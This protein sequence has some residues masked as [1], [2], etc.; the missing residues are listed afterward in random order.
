MAFGLGVLRLAPAAF[1]AAT[2]R[3]LVAAGRALNGSG[4]GEAP[5][6]GALDALM[7]RF[8]DIR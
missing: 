3:E 6:R 2:P 4:Q 5:S 1:W 7:R 8:P